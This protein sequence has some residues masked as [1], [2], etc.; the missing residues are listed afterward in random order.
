M[1]AGKFVAGI[2]LTIL[3]LASFE[4]GGFWIISGIACLGFILYL[5][6]LEYSEDEERGENEKEKM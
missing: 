3:S 2:V 6:S 5:V 1:S 4:A